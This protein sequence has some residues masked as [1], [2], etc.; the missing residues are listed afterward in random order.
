MIDPGLAQR[1]DKLILVRHVRELVPGLACVVRSCQ[2]CLRDHSFI[3]LSDRKTGFC[4]TD[5]KPHA[6]QWNI[7]PY[8][9]VVKT[10]EG[11]CFFH[12]I[13]ESRLWRVDT[14]ITIKKQRDKGQPAPRELAKLGD[15]R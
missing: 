15:E 8:S 3:L 2:E 12:A 4:G 6:G 11:M 5:Q 9:C 14:G 10:D 13:Q 1:E 7:T